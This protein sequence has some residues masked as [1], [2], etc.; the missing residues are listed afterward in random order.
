[1]V[2]TIAGLAGSFGSAD[3]TNTDARF[4]PPSGVAVDNAGNLYV[5]DRNN[6]LIRKINIAGNAVTT[7]SCGPSCPTPVT[8]NPRRDNSIA[9]RPVPHP[10]S[11]TRR[12]PDS[13]SSDSTRSASPWT[14]WPF[15]AS[16]VHRAS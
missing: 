11:S 3:G 9:T 13:A 12:Q 10:A 7:V 5:A 8:E 16:V 15:A 4:G 6:S 14:L 2:S 1:V